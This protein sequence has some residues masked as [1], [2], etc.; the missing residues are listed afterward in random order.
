MWNYFRFSHQLRSI[1]LPCE[2]ITVQVIHELAK[3]CP[4]VKQM[5]LDFSKATQVKFINILSLIY[6]YSWKEDTHVVPI[7]TCVLS[8]NVFYII[9]L[10]KHMWRCLLIVYGGK[11]FCMMKSFVETGLCGTFIK[12]IWP[13]T[14]A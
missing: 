10:F 7:Q 6:T 5:T 1:D 2:F 11:T 4:S 14:S 13:W 12:L 9:E 8:W 3:E